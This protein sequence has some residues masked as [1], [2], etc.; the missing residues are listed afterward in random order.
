MLETAVPDECFYGIGAWPPSAPPNNQYPLAGACTAPGR[1][2]TNESYVWGMTK[3]GNNV[4]F[5]T[6][7]KDFIARSRTVTLGASYRF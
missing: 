6:G 5:G 1:L 2:K 3:P 7:Q 4:F